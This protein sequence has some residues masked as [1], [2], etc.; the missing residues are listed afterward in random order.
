ML[1]KFLKSKSS[2]LIDCETFSDKIFKIFREI[3]EERNIVFIDFDFKLLLGGT[4]PWYFSMENFVDDD[5]Y[6]PNIIFDGVDV[7]VEGLGTHVQGR[8]DIDWF[9]GIGSYSFSK[10]K[11]SNFRDFVLDQ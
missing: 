2:V 1:D 8:T 4:V 9:F 11:I 10:A 5:T 6:R 7:G 3:F